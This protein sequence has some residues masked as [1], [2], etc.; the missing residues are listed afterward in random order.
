MYM[1][2][3]ALFLL[4]S[5]ELFSYA[6]TAAPLPVP[7]E[8]QAATETV[9]VQISTSAIKALILAEKRVRGIHLT[10]WGAGSDN[11]RKEL[12]RKISGS[13]INTVV[14]AVK[15][16]DG[17][18]YI[19]GVEKA[20]KYGSYLGAIS[21][22]EAMMKDFK[23]AGLYTVARIVTFKDKVLPKVRPDLAVKTP[24]GVPWRS[25]NGSTW[26]DPY[27]REVWDY[28]LDIAEQ[29]AKLGFEEIQF[30]YIRYPS[31]GNTSLCRY[32]KPNNRKA[33]INN[34]AEFLAYAAKR[35]AP[36]KVKISA[37]VFG[38]TT[39]VKDDMGIG[40]DINVLAAGSDYIY[41]MMYPSHYA[42]G[43][44]HIKNPNGSPFKV[45]NRGLKDAMAKLGPDYA[46]LR[47]YLQDFSLGWNYGPSEVRAQL[48]ATRLN[49]L[50]S[51]VLWNP[52]N[53]YTWAA[54]TPQSYRAFVD[55]EYK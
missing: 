34:L 48:M 44:Y 28:T 50:E 51:W 26:L 37:D 31:E 18:V 43:E 33:A 35:L 11:S 14:I 41:P 47:P 45:I 21:E 55:P 22:P 25:R 3:T 4:L 38:L 2:H 10:S 24:A 40:Q 9:K 17:R 32:S 13:V 20:H 46:K 8:A 19:P 53:R 1:L 54:L 15:E 7:P 42:P 52:A 36:Y 29:C 23:G 16:T 12:I 6:Q 27:S 39:T 5:G 30:D 49:L